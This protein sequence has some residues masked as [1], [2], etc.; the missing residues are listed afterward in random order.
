MVFKYHTYGNG[1]RIPYERVRVWYLNTIP[2]WNGT[3]IPYERVR[4][5]YL[6]TIPME[7]VSGYHMRGS[8]YGI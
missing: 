4:V 5:W 1:I 3:R 2:I 6:N 8:G 7:M